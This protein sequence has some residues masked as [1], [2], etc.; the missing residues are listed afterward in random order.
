[1]VS[2]TL[3]AVAKADSSYRLIGATRT[4]T[5]AKLKVAFNNDWG[6]PCLNLANRQVEL[7]YYRTN[8]GDLVEVTRTFAGQTQKLYYA[9]KGARSLGVFEMLGKGTLELSISY[10]KC[11]VASGETLY[12]SASWLRSA[13]RWGTSSEKGLENCAIV[14][15]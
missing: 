7:F 5:G 15:P 3:P 12:T 10:K 11:G 4:K 8:P 1:M 6:S 2:L 14:L 13:H 9:R